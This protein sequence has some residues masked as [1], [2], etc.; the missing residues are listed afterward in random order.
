MALYATQYPR[1]KTKTRH[2]IFLEESLIHDVG[3]IRHAICPAPQLHK[4]RLERA[5]ERIAE[6]R[7]LIN[8]DI[9]RVYPVITVKPEIRTPVLMSVFHN[10]PYT[11]EISLN[12]RSH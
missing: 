6:Y 9:Q 12:K 1:P 3:N 8:W 10:R 2:F 7:I 5:F 11:P 4:L